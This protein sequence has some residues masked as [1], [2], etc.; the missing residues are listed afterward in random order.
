MIRVIVVAELNDGR[1]VPVAIAQDEEDARK[2]IEMANEIFG[3]KGIVNYEIEI[4]DP[5]IVATCH[6]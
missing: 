2:A 1:K 4:D 6:N 3:M 5:E